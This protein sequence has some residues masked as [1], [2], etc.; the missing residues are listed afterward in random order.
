MLQINNTQHAKKSARTL[1]RFLAH[2]G[3]ELGHGR[4]LDA[5]AVLSGFKDW[6]ALSHA[7]SPA[8]VDARLDEFER[9]HARDAAGN[10]Y[11]DECAVVT[12]TGFEL[13]YSAQGDTPDY[14]RVCDPLGRE[15]AYWVSDE[16]RDDP[17]LVMGAILGALV[18]GMP[19]VRGSGKESAP[20]AAPQLQGSATEDN[21]SCSILDVPFHDVSNLVLNGDAYMVRFRDEAVLAQLREPAGDADS[22]DDCHHVAL[23]LARDEDGLLW[24]ES[25]TLATLRALTWNGKLEC[26]E[27]PEGDCYTFYVERKFRPSAS[28]KSRQPLPTEHS[29]VPVRELQ[30]EDAV[31]VKLYEAEVFADWTN[32][33]KWVGGARNEAEARARAMESRW[34]TRLD[35]AGARA[36]VQVSVAD[37]SKHGPFVVEIDGQFYAEVEYFRRAVDAAELMLE[38][39]E[40]QTTVLSAFGDELMTFNK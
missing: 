29:A 20:A 39:A 26:F 25:V 10:D 4:A 6:N 12:H 31:G 32:L 36:T 15:V 35:A 18:R 37:E 13:R 21:A 33:G 30:A 3:I 38:T 28:A 27:S 23:Q 34:D 22:E 8:A 2:A 7:L 1:E 17:E 14:V 40:S 11:G 24:E 5:M 16:W 19:L 9:Q